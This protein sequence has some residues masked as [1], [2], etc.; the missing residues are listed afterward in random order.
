MMRALITGV[1]G[2][3]GRH[4]AQY[5]TTQGV[6]V[7]GV[8]RNSIFAKCHRFPDTIDATS[9]LPAIK[10]SRPHYIFHLAGVMLAQDPATFYRVN[11]VYAASLLHALEA[12]GYQDRPVLLVG[13][14]TEYGMI[15]P[16]QLPI[17]EKSVARPYN[18][19]GSSKL[20][21]TLL[22]L[23]RAKRGR[24][25]VVVR[26]FNIIGPG[27]PSHLVVQSFAAQLAQVLKGDM[28][29]ILRVGNLGSS[30]DFIDVADAV[31]IYWQLVR[32]P[33]AYGEIVNVCSGYPVII[34]DILTKL[35]ALAGVRVEI[36]TD[37]HRLKAVDVPVHYG[38]TEKLR[39]ILGRAS[40]VSLDLSLRR[41][42]EA[43]IR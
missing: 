43:A 29:P 21:Q 16:G 8:S 39:Q 37:P 19:Y 15:S 35:A 26:P 25:I 5:L 12:T 38:S 17:H 7:H 14:A 40:T 22:G 24:P 31:E 20:A 36:Q 33:A 11:T 9:F 6:E 13:T 18:D 10:A 3:C 30:R 28:P 2:F 1:G 34:G 32:T 27:M 23:A 4:L 41:V 42:L